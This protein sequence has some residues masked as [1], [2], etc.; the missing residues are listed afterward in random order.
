[1]VVLGATGSQASALALSKLGAKVVSA[2]FSN[3]ESVRAALAG[4]NAIFAIT[5]FWDQISLDTELSQV[6]TINKIASQLPALE[7]Y[8]LSSLPDGRTLAGGKFQNILP[9]NAKAYIR[10][11]LVKNHPGLWAK[12]T[13]FFVT[14]Y[15]QNW[16]KYSTVLGPYKMC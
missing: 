9:Y 6:K 2:N 12:T 16:V 10:N 3:A 4:A 13:E 5:N 7:H 15:F 1:M 11:D 8:I 14:F